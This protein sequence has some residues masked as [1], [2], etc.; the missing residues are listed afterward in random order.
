MLRYPLC[1][2]PHYVMAVD[3][4]GLLLNIRL[5]SLNHFWSTKSLYGMFCVSLTG[6][7][8]QALH[9]LGALPLA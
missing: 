2:V 4:K 5:Q 6:Q 3:I 1:T 8:N 9:G 7:A